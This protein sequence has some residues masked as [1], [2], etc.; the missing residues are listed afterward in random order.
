MTHNIVLI[1]LFLQVYKRKEK[2]KRKDA[3]N[4]FYRKRI[5]INKSDVLISY[6]QGEYTWKGLND[7]VVVGYDL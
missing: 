2:K 7:I 5:A 6:L 3:L 1:Y 4:N